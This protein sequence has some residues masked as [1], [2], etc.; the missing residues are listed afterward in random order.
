M[1]DIDKLLH[2]NAPKPRR[3]L[4]ADFTARTLHKLTEHHPSKLGRLKETF[5]MRFTHFTRAHKP[6]TI[7]AAVIGLI[8]ISGTASAATIG[9]PN[10][11]ALF[12]GQTN[13]ADGSRIVQVNTNHCSFKNA[14]NIT[15]KDSQ[16]DN[17]YYY[18]VKPHSQLTNE[19]IVHMVQG[20]CEFEAESQLNTQALERI[21]GKSANQNSD[22]VGGYI[23]NVIT[24]ITPTSLSLT[25]DIHDYAHNKDNVYT[26]NLPHIDPNVIV[27][28]RGNQIKLTDLKV[29]DHI[30]YIYK[31]TGDA[32]NHSETLA[33]WQVNTND[34]TVEI[35]TKNPDSVTA[36]LTFT[37]SNYND[38]EQVVPCSKQ[39]SGYCNIQ[40]INQK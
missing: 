29:G 24:A 1:N 31:A 25:V 36:A 26:I 23:D 32:L 37:Q 7:A 6:A 27:L 11:M 28:D 17:V 21:T 38:F 15:Q 34:I 35:I 10:I 13:N 20:S 16:G 14:F 3:E 18:R 33:P 9:W 22:F 40:E 8:V 39:P 2:A 12:G 19:Q 4:K 5:T 30:T